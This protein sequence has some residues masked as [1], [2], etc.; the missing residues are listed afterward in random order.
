MAS[1]QTRTIGVV[2]FGQ[3]LLV[4]PALNSL[5]FTA[6]T[7][8][9]SLMLSFKQ[10]L[11]PWIFYWGDLGFWIWSTSPALPALHPL[12]LTTF[13]F[14]LFPIQCKEN[15][16]VLLH[17]SNPLFLG[18][19]DFFPLLRTCLVSAYASKKFFCIGFVIEPTS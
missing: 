2:I 15:E 14:T 9:V 11:Q 3:C 4:L 5:C 12:C 6:F 19:C 7:F 13:S 17:T 16:V 10:P 8:A 1:I 18:L